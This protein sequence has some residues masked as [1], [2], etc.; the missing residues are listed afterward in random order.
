MAYWK[1]I[2]AYVPAKDSVHL[3]YLRKWVGVNKSYPLAYELPILIALSK[4]HLE[5]IDL[6]FVEGDYPV[7]L[8][9]EALDGER[10]L[11][12]WKRSYVV[13]ISRSKLPGR[14]ADLTYNAQIAAISSVLYDLELL[15]QRS[16]FAQVMAWP[17]WESERK[18]LDKQ[19]VKEKYLAS[20]KGLGF[21][22]ANLKWETSQWQA[23]FSTE[24]LKAFSLEGLENPDTNH[25]LWYEDMFTNRVDTVKVLDLNMQQSTPDYLVL[26]VL[27]NQDTI[28]LYVPKNRMHRKDYHKPEYWQMGKRYRMH[29]S[30]VGHYEIGGFMG[31]PEQVGMLGTVSPAIWHW[32]DQKRIQ[33]VKAR[34]GRDFWFF[35]EMMPEGKP[36][37]LIGSALRLFVDSLPFR[38]AL[39][40]GI[41]DTLHL[42]GD[43]KHLKYACLDGRKSDRLQWHPK[44]ERKE[45][46]FQY[47]LEFFP[48]DYRN[49]GMRFTFRNGLGLEVVVELERG[50]YGG[51]RVL[52][53]I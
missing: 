21:Q 44:E 38:T 40:L 2:R 1:P 28:D 33:T 5:T 51:M 46:Y 24:L 29:I 10:R 39:G 45:E 11:P 52:G 17:W 20:Q 26:G 53:M 49:Q 31:S 37:S 7:A 43:G 36:P 32:L 3:S 27:L 35:H 16:H 50:D 23:G 12:P 4:F 8:S 48:I 42:I 6:Q 13:N 34:E 22:L 30:K 15:M 9:I 41:Q 18:A 47:H 19:L 14:L 25:G